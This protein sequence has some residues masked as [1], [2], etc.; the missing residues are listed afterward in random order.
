MGGAIAEEYLEGI[1]LT[2]ETVE[3]ITRIIV[4]HSP[5]SM[6]P[7]ESPAEKVAFANEHAAA[8]KSRGEG[9]VRC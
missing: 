6:L 2:N 5:T 3:T 1:D 7:P 8:R 9:R 4:R